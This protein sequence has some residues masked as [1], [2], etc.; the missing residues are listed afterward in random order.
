MGRR[1]PASDLITHLIALACQG[2][3]SRCVAH[4]AAECGR[5]DVLR[6]V[7]EEMNG[8]D[9]QI[10]QDVLQD[11]LMVEWVGML[12]NYAR[13][14]Y[15]IEFEPEVPLRYYFRQVVE[16]SMEEGGGGRELEHWNHLMNVPIASR[17]VEEI[18][19]KLAIPN[20]QEAQTRE[21]GAKA[22]YDLARLTIAAR[23]EELETGKPTE[24]LSALVEKYF[25]EGIA[26]P[27]ADEEYLT[28]DGVETI[29][30]IGPD[31]TDDAA[32]IRYDPSN[33]TMSRGDIFIESHSLEP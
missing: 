18:L 10:N 28:E 14:G 22:Q 29:Y 23:I 32:G 9:K 16:I 24:D 15:E 21:L 25:P 27:F 4:L 11:A 31:G 30:S 13:R 17:A 8:L 33:G 2:I 5:P 1:H 26:D 6:G 7:L 19:V 12:R 3:A 20:F